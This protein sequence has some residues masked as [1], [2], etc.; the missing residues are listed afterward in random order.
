MSV[1]TSP[2]GVGG[3]GGSNAPDEQDQNLNEAIERVKHEAFQM[4]RCLD[5]AR[6]SEALKHATTMLFE[7]RTSE[8]SPKNYYELYMVVCDEL[9]HLQRHLTDEFGKGNRCAELYELV[10]YAGNIIP[11]L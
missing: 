10:Q 2:G 5:K 11:R 7:L 8:L 9:G 4:K 6:L 1:R 3:G